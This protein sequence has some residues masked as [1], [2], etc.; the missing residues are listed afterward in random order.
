MINFRFHIVSLI[1]VFLALA[2]GVVMGYGVLGQPTVDTLQQRIDTVERRANQIRSE[3]GTLW[4]EQSRL[5]EVLGASNDFSVAGRLAGITTLP[6]AARGIDE[7]R[8]GATVQLARKA[9]GVV[10]GV[11][12]LEAKWNLST[13]ADATTL[14]DLV[15]TTS[16]ARNAVREAGL[17]AL[18]VRLADGPS[19][20]ARVDLLTALG[21][22]GFVSTSTVDGQAFDLAS[23]TWKVQWAWVAGGTKGQVDWPRVLAPLTRDLVVGNVSVVA[24]DTWA[25]AAG[26]PERGVDFAVIRQD[27]VTGPKV[28]TVDDLDRVDGPLAVV[29]GLAERTRGAVGHYGSGDGAKSVLPAWWVE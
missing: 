21:D 17:K 26:G 4:A 25:Q 27:S 8:I 7:A 18:A 6:I 1:A 20:T 23:I 13:A 22:A 5:E 3:N 11:L 10:P 24:S 19:V 12:W 14:A 16:T 29:L 15:G 28:T 9:G 2:I